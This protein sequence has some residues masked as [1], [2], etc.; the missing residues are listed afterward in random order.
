MTIPTDR[1]PIGYLLTLVDRP[2]DE[3][4]SRTA[5]NLPRRHWQLLS[6]ACFHPPSVRHAERAAVVVAPALGVGVNTTVFTVTNG[7]IL[8]DLPV[9]EP[10]RLM[11]LGNVMRT[12]HPWRVVPGVSRLA[13]GI[14]GVHRPC[15]VRGHRHESR[16]EDR[17][18]DHLAGCIV[19]G[20]G[21]RVRKLRR[22]WRRLDRWFRCS[23]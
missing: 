15:G 1:R 9:G 17:S 18:A 12:T 3:R 4:L 10:G 19:S 22:R 5:G 2:I 14:A 21:R 11:H 20:N 8:R 6:S 23:C 7:W 13:G 16:V